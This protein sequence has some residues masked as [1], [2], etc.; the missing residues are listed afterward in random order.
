[1]AKNN[2]S[3]HYDAFRM[4]QTPQAKNPKSVMKQVW[5]WIKIVLIIFFV[6]IGLVG[7]IQSVATKSG[8]K[9]GSGQEVLTK[10]DY[11][12]PNIVTLRW[13][14]FKNEFENVNLQKDSGIAANTYLGLDDPEQ[15]KALRD[16]DDKTGGQY[17]IYG[18][19][20][21]A[22]QLQKQKEN[23]KNP[24]SNSADWQNI[25]NIE[26][27]NEP[28]KKG[29]VYGNGKRHIYVNFGDGKGN[30]KTKIY[31]PVNKLSDIYVPINLLFES[32]QKW[33]KSGKDSITHHDYTHIKSLEVAKVSLAATSN[34]DIYNLLLSDILTSLIIETFNTW[35]NDKNNSSMFGQTIAKRNAKTI[36]QL[37]ALPREQLIDEWNKYIL[38]FKNSVGPGTL[39]F[40][41]EEGKALNVLFSSASKMMKSYLSMTSFV[42]TNRPSNDLDFGKDINH[43]YV[44]SINEA[45]NYKPDHWKFKLFNSDALVP[46]KPISTYKEFWNHG[47]F[48]GI[49]VHP[50][51]HFMNSIIRS[52]GT[53]GWSVILA[54]VVTVIIVRLVTFFL[55]AKSIFS[56]NKMEELNQKK[57]KIEAKY[58]AYKY[59]KQMQQRKQM[60]ISEL[61]KKEKISPVAQFVS[62]LITLPILI[63]VFRIVSTSPEI[64]QVTL[65]TIQLSATSVSRIFRAKEMQYLPIVLLSTGVQLL[66]QF[67]PKILKM[68]KKKS[69]RADAY[70]QAAM[71]K[72]NKKAMI[73]PIV[74]V[75]IGLFFSAGLQIYWVIG[76]LFTICQ[77]IAVHY[78]QKT[79]W[80]KHKLE[81]W[82]FKKEATA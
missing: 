5:K 42:K 16:Q 6:G 20:S 62:S 59:D 74:F 73:I 7:C 63:V 61:Y 32:Y 55:S 35:L 1:M 65:Y 25:S 66:A 81:P 57:A 21:F 47:P 75:F 60:E 10:K 49:F 37:K 11:I 52:L 58:E 8:V 44:S 72:S 15:I 39:T 53:T 22:L 67:M 54:L 13:N 36:E 71:K 45:G 41:E 68:R 64:K 34:S 17:G 76:G 78:I 3:K 19:S 77:H 51:T 50:F 12:S 18:G 2:S 79:K 80:Y 24:S 82:L 9:V 33:P 30:G 27:K 29:V 14:K 31:N 46:H 43:Y 38:S 23:I 26:I 48:Y 56:A 70:Q 4:N 69:L 40:T 28:G